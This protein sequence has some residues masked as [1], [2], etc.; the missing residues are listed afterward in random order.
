MS[1][2]TTTEWGTSGS[3]LV[4]QVLGQL[5]EQPVR[6]DQLHSLLFRLSQQLLSQL[7]LIQFHRHG[8]ECF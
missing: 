3:E 4:E 2:P 7:P 6:A 1:K 8:I 5:V